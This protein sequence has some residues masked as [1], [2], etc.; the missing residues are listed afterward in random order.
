MRRMLG[1]LGLLLLCLSVSGASLQRQ[2]RA[3]LQLMQGGASGTI[4]KR[5]QGFANTQSSGATTTLSVSSL[6][7]N[8]S[9]NCYATV[10]LITRQNVSS[11]SC[12]AGA[13]AINETELNQGDISGGIFETYMAGEEAITGTVTFTCTWTTSSDAA[14]VVR[15]YEYVD[16][17]TPVEASAC[18]TDAGADLEATVDVTGTTSGNLVIDTVNRESATTNPMLPGAN[19]TADLNDVTRN[20]SNN[21][22]I[23]ASYEA[24]GGTITMSWDWTTT[25]RNWTICAMS[26]VQS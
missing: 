11:Q 21:S 25:N 18:N 7:T 12:T 26:L 24:A 8:C 4:A 20:A 10:G 15:V 23:G 1:F 9:T 13:T 16:Q 5:A 17:T 3:I 2:H 19:Q 6:N 22:R 14:M